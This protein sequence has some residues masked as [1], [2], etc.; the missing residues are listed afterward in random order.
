[1]TAFPD[2][3]SSLRREMD[4]ALSDVLPLPAG[5]ESRVVEAARYS[6]L[7]GGKRLRPSLLL[8]T[9]DMFGLPHSETLPF[10][11]ALEMIHTYSLIHDDLP[12]MDD[13]DLRRGRPT[14]HR[15]YDEAT[16]VLA[17]DLL[18]NA[19]FEIL[20][21]HCAQP[22]GTVGWQARVHAA[23][24]MARKAG[25][26]GMIGGQAVD[27]QYEQTPADETSLR[28][29]HRMKTGALL[30]A[31]MLVPADLA[32]PDPVLV[33]SLETYAD[34]VGL[35]FQIGDDL[36]DAT[37]TADQLGKTPG[38]DARDHKSTY[39]SLLGLHEAEKRLREACERSAAALGTLAGAGLDPAFL[40][41]LTV[42][43]TERES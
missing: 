20:L 41:G 19:A 3:F 21:A 27:M 42:F 4:Q 40:E 36:L 30:E 6:L 9:G 1:M 43:L 37:A 12:C 11:C 34:Q 35:A 15:Q 8:A 31:A 25:I 29:M 39:V 14:C 7:G 26:E 24:R 17:G 28:R 18:L 13:D 22:D 2:S 5:P 33:A 23:R 32:A 38:K 10:A 16:A